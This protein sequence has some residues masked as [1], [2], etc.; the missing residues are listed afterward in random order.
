MEAL[1]FDPQ[2]SPKIV[3]K[4]LA[5]PPENIHPYAPPPCRE[6]Q[7]VGRGEIEGAL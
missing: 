4:G 6:A 5:S 1:K 2:P 7:K 3:K